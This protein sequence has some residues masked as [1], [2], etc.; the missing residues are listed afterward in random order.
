MWDHRDFQ[1]RV[2]WLWKELAQHYKDNPWIA[3]FNVLN[4]PCDVQHHRLIDLYNRLH[5]AIRQ[6][7]SLHVI[8]LDGN[9]FASDFSQFGDAY[10]NWTNTAYSIHDYSG[11]GF[12]ASPEPYV[13]SDE[14]KARLERGFQRKQAWM[15]EK[16]LCVWNGEWGPVYARRQYDGDQTDPINESRYLL[17]KDQ[18]AIYDKVNP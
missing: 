6:I 16:G 15:V 9:T 17:L 13:G 11:F 1:D 4:E 18:L 12:P 8:F 14:Q 3:G 2:V 10:K 7:D 5:D